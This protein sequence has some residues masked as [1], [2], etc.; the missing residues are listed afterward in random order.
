MPSNNTQ[1]V[2]Y[3]NLSNDI[4]IKRPSQMNKTEK[5]AIIYQALTKEGFSQYEVSKIVD[6]D[7]AHINRIAKREAAGLIAPLARIAKR[8]VKALAKGELVGNMKEIKGSDVLGACNT[9]LDRADPKVN[10]QEIKSF[11]AH[12]EITNEDRDRLIMSLGLLGT[13]QDVVLDGQKELVTNNV[14]SN[15][16]DNK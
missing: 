10:K 6:C 14:S 5:K 11:S 9:I 8:S 13:P 7:P 4:T 1:I 2:N 12:V 16:L 3:T 15:L